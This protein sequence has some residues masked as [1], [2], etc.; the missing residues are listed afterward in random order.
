MQATL[1]GENLPA[2]ALLGKRLTALATQR[3]GLHA[4]A[5][6][7]SEGFAMHAALRAERTPAFGM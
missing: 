2:V 3:S 7:N 6:S 4:A 1:L 5:A